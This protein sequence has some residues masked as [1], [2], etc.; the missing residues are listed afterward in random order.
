M[1][2]F[3]SQCT[4]ALV[5]AI[6]RRSTLRALQLQIDFESDQQVVGVFDAVRRNTNLWS[7]D[8]VFSEFRDFSLHFFRVHGS[9]SSI[10]F[11]CVV[12]AALVT[13]ATSV[14]CVCRLLAENETLTS[15]R[16]R[17][18]RAAMLDDCALTSRRVA[19]QTWPTLPRSSRSCSARSPRTTPCATAAWSSFATTTTFIESR[20]ATK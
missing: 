1:F 18:P 8:L 7:L 4:A 15:F 20:C 2:S 16:T 19:P 3:P 17:A 9:L 11:A 14:D 5:D 12:A 13:S 10:F 6:E